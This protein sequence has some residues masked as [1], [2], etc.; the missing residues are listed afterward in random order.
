MIVGAAEYI[1][2]NGAVEFND[3]EQVCFQIGYRG[4]PHAKIINEQTVAFFLEARKLCDGFGCGIYCILFRQLNPEGSWINRCI[5]Y[6]MRN[7]LFQGSIFQGFACDI[8]R[9]LEGNFCML[10]DCSNRMAGLVEN[11]FLQWRQQMTAFG[12]GNDQWRIDKAGNGMLPA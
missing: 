9:Y 8:Y 2:G 11:E 3:I 6:G 1:A 4:M 12:Q 7:G 10:P 5:L